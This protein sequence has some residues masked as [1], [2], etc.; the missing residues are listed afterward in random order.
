MSYGQATDTERRL[1]NLVMIGTV[2]EADYPGRRYRVR[3]GNILTAW[4]KYSGS[5]AGALRV[6]SPL[7]VGEQV[8]VA[9]PSG[10]L[11]QGV[12]LGSIES[13]ANPS[14]GS[15]GGTINVVFPDGSTLDFGGG[16]LSFQTAAAVKIKAASI[17][18]EAGQ[19]TIKGPVEQSG[20]EITAESDVVAAGISLVT[21]VHS[22]VT[23]GP[24]MTGPPL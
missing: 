11:A 4:L 1:A 23:P 22:G 24:G 2:A 10:D 3:A 20:G 6:W 9:S 7:T 5:R 14:P 19:I 18:M 21:H 12:I 13:G 8:I 17:E 16:E 15:D